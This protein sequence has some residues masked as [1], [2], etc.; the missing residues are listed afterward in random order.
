MEKDLAVVL[1][2]DRGLR[3]RRARLVDLEMLGLMILSKSDECQAKGG[4][5]LQIDVYVMI[6]YLILCVTL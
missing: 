5:L 4:Y 1:P 6:P 3:G 2:V